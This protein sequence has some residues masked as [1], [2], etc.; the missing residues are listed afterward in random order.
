MVQKVNLIVAP[1]R[2]RT[3]MSLNILDDLLCGGESVE[4]FPTECL[5]MIIHCIELTIICVYGN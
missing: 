2:V 3:L 5:A 4:M 1:K